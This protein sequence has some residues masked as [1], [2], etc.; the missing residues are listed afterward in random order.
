MKDQGSIAREKTNRLWMAQL[1]KRLDMAMCL[2]E[3][4]LE[5][6]DCQGGSHWMVKRG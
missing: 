2:T 5:S 1:A 4:K 3:H 6:W